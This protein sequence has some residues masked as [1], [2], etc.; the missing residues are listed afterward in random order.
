MQNA[1]R[2][3]NRQFKAQLANPNRHSNITGCNVST[4]A[5][6][7]KPQNVYNRNTSDSGSGLVENN[8][9]IMKSM[10]LKSAKTKKQDGQSSKN[11]FGSFFYN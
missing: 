7:N 5:F 8:S 3:N 11:F 2:Q 4:N 9:P 1:I 6:N 10:E